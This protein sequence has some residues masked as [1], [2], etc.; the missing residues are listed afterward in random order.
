MGEELDA[1]ELEEEPSSLSLLSDVSMVTAG[2]GCEAAPLKRK[3]MGRILPAMFNAG[4]GETRCCSF[5]GGVILTLGEDTVRLFPLS[6][7]LLFPPRL[8]EVAE[9]DLEGKMLTLLL[10]LLEA[11]LPREVPPLMTVVEPGVGGGG[12]SSYSSGEYLDMVPVAFKLVVRLPNL[13]PSAAVIGTGSS[14]LAPS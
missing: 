13:P 12:E 2:S 3:G 11:G 4:G 8:H 7:E 10:M 14:P 5:G 1:A 9:S 6:T